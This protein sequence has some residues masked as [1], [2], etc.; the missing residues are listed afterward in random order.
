M[1]ILQN[2]FTNISY[3]KHFHDTYSIS[4]VLSGECNVD[5][6]GINYNFKKGDIRIVN[7]YEYH[8]IYKSSWE[9][10]NIVLSKFEMK[11]I[12]RYIVDFENYVKDEEL[13]S[14]IR[15]VYE[16]KK[17]MEKIIEYISKNYIKMSYKDKITYAKKFKKALMYIYQNAN[18][19]DINLDNIVAFTG[20]SK[21]H[22]LREFKK[23][24]NL[25][26]YQ[27][28][29]NIKINNARKLIRSNLPLSQVALK[30]GFTDQA[31]FIN[32]YKKFFGHTPSKLI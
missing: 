20:L 1:Y 30:C 14:D 17:G 8:Q 31:H 22:F 2:S 9:H 5:I 25:T 4:A 7:P 29:L 24:F 16:T 28:I 15:F 6:E 12:L 19:Q 13:F 21:Y 27:Y 23:E 11:H 3:K 32:T 26:P 18:H 10:I